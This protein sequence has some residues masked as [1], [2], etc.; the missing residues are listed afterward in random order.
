[1]Y[2]VENRLGMKMPFVLE[3][4]NS[5][6]VGVR[7]LNTKTEGTKRNKKIRNTATQWHGG[8]KKPQ[9]Q[10]PIAAKYW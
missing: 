10:P 6:G 4:Q 9:H 8:Q 1:M 5:D 7:K 2:L 3:G